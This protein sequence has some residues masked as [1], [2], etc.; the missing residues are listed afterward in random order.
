MTTR[1][2]PTAAEIFGAMQA[3]WPK[4][5]AIRYVDAITG[6]TFQLRTTRIKI[7]EWITAATLDESH[8]FELVSTGGGKLTHVA[9]GGEVKLLNEVG[10]TDDAN[11]ETWPGLASTGEYQAGHSDSEGDEFLISAEN[12]RDLVKLGASFHQRRLESLARQAEVV[13]ERHGENLSYFSGLLKMAG[14]LDSVETS[15]NLNS[16]S[17]HLVLMLN[18]AGITA[19]A[20]VLAACGIEPEQIVT[21]HPLPEASDI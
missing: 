1:T 4:G 2:P 11:M 16:D 7:R 12:L 20:D 13:R 18:D 5:G 14:V 19:V 6:L 21:R 9:R 3:G 8:P 15:Y 10:Y 17:T